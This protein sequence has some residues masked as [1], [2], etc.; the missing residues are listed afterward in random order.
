MGM[1]IEGVGLVEFRRLINIT[2]FQQFNSKQTKWTIRYRK[3]KF[4]ASLY[5]F[6]WMLSMIND[7]QNNYKQ[8][9]I[10]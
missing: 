1:G 8:T 9:M 7:C 10:N 6:F 4:F 3:W 2:D 5:L